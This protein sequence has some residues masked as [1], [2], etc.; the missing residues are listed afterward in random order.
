MIYGF[1]EDKSFYPDKTIDLGTSD[2][3]LACY[4]DSNMEAYFYTKATILD[5]RDKRLQHNNKDITGLI[6]FYFDNYKVDSDENIFSS[7]ITTRLKVLFNI[8]ERIYM[9]DQEALD[10]IEDS[11]LNES[12]Y[13]V[14]SGSSLLFGYKENTLKLS[15][16]T[17][18]ATS[19]QASGNFTISLPY[20]IQFT[21]IDTNIIEGEGDSSTSI[22][23]EYEF[24][25]WLSRQGFLDEY[26]LS[27]I[28]KVIL[29]CDHTYILDPTKFTNAINAVINSAGFSFP[30]IDANDDKDNIF[31][32]N[33]GTVSTTDNSGLFTYYTKYV[34]SSQST[35]QLPFGILYKGT[36]PSTA[37]IRKAIR[38]HLLGFGD[39]SESTWK[40]LLPE[41]FVIAQF[42]FIPIWDHKTERVER[43]MYSSVIGF[44]Q[45]KNRFETLQPNVDSSYIENYQE[46]ITSAQSEI[47]MTT[48]PDIL[49]ENDIFSIYEIYPTYQNHSQ[50]E[51][52]YAYQ[53]DETKEFNRKLNRCMSVLMG[54]SITEGDI[55]MTTIDENKY[56]SFVA[57]AIDKNNDTV[58]V[59]FHVLAEESYNKLFNE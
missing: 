38:E 3:P 25:I 21:I 4:L 16:S 41:L 22:T 26:P 13:F 28:L 27:T 34:T 47:Y 2:L 31:K 42:Y 37:M 46:I 56:G 44:K 1:L 7:I 40:E 57:S 9:A 15:K 59:E 11:L 43:T 52:A 17:V 33:L 12:T 24:R 30:K 48:L 39:A 18:G 36:Q 5:P 53:T 55:T 49:N 45:F 20:Y 51:P 58:T 19:Y 32:N 35:V 23:K 50:S 6:K 54:E 8:I 29:P 14:K 10:S